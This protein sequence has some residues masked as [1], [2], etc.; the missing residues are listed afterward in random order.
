MAIIVGISVVP[1]SVTT[2][3]VIM[4]KRPE[5]YVGTMFIIWLVGNYVLHFAIFPAR[6]DWYTYTGLI[7]SALQCLAAWIEFRLPP[8]ADVA[9]ERGV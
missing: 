6:T 7:Q 3:T 4:K 5:Q 2:Y 8:L 9:K 1:I